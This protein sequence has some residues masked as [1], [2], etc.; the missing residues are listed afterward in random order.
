LVSF[1]SS[2]SFLVLFNLFKLPFNSFYNSL[3]GRLE[4]FRKILLLLVYHDMDLTREILKTFK[5]FL[6]IRRQG[7]LQ[8]VAGGLGLSGGA[9]SH[10]RKSISVSSFGEFARQKIGSVGRLLFTEFHKM[11]SQT[12]NVPLDR[13]DSN[14]QARPSSVS[15][16][17]LLSI[18]F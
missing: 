6:E 7:E 13:H 14:E 11:F 17:I 9:A 3:S 18:L 10:M 4:G 5:R 8:S 16:N 2:I 1:Y 15:S 12:G